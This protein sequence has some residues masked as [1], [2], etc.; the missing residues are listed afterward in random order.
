MITKLTS[1]YQLKDW[2]RNLRDITINCLYLV[3]P[4]SP[5][6]AVFV[7]VIYLQTTHLVPVIWLSWIT[8]QNNPLL[9]HAIISYSKVVTSETVAGEEVKSAVVKTLELN[10]LSKSKSGESGIAG[11]MEERLLMRL[12]VG[13]LLLVVVSSAGTRL[14]FPHMAYM[15]SGLCTTLFSEP[16][17]S[18]WWF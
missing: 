3:R 15:F 9:S 4:P 16:W 17:L 13:Q 1:Q 11:R 14:Y 7:T 6:K 12:V 8:L 2:F 18:Q 5:I 10:F